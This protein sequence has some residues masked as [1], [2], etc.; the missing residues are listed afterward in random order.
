M[1]LAISGGVF[2]LACVAF[3][4]LRNKLGLFWSAAGFFLATVL[5]AEFGFDPAAPASVVKLY[6]FC[7]LVA[8]VIYVTSTDAALESFWNPIEAIMV[9]PWFSC[10]ASWPGRPTSRRS[11]PQ[12]RRPRFAP[13]TRRRQTPST[14]RHLE[15]PSP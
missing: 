13:F 1:H 6:A 14:S 2:L 12:S 9:E 8:M 5:F 7:V 4:L 15:M 10:L 3:F 11:L